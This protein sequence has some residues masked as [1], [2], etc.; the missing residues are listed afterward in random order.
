MTNFLPIFT[1]VPINEN[2]LRALA[3]DSLNL[4]NI[5]TDALPSCFLN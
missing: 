2:A 1:T 3:T 4:L 5:A